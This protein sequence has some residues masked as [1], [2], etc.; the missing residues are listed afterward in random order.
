MI[1]ERNRT[2]SSL[3]VLLPDRLRQRFDRSEQ[4]LDHGRQQTAPLVD[5]GEHRIPPYTGRRKAR[6]VRIEDNGV[7]RTP[8]P[9]APLP[10]ADRAE[11][12]LVADAGAGDRCPVVS[13]SSP[14]V[15][16]RP[17][18]PRSR[19]RHPAAASQRVP[20]ERA[21]MAQRA[22]VK[23]NPVSDAQVPETFSAPEYATL[24]SCYR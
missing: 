17:A 1:R 9:G 19:A 7:A 5:A 12:Q 14:A 18:D 10:P 23:W 13:A 6:A 15:S 20:A 21:Q 3:P 16:A 11:I 4:I 8:V 2:A 24:R 22:M